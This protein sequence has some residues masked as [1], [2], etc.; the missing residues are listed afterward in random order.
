[1]D[2][3]VEANGV[4]GATVVKVAGEV[5]V[6]TAPQLREALASATEGDGQQVIVDL[7]DVDFLDSTGLGVLVFG[8]K[9]VR[10]RGGDL[11][12]VCRHEQILKVLT[13]TGLSKILKV[14]ASIEE[15]APAAS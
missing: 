2:V 11:S 5:D 9:R 6:F 7:E 8:L 3:R 4:G 15:A 14:H 10:E 1:M 12:V 13:I